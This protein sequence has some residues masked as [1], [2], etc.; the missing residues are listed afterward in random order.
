MDHTKMIPKR[1]HLLL[2]LRNLELKG[3]IDLTLTHL[4]MSE[5]EQQI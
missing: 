1:H 2:E 4:K 5:L 3:I